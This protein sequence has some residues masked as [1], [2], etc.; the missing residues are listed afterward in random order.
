LHAARSF[1]WIS[2]MW[3]TLDQAA[4]LLRESLYLV[5]LVSAPAVLTSLAVGLLVSWSDRDSAAGPHPFVRTETRGRDACP[6][7]RGNLG[8]I[9]A[10]ALCE[11][12]DLRY[13][14]REGAW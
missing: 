9:P 3:L 6:G 5:L 14:S 11:Q 7:P 8:P 10:R 1:I 4:H 2:A 12:G 13:R